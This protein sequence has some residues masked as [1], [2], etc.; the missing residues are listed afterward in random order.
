MGLDKLYDR[1][2]EMVM[3][4]NSFSNPIKKQKLSFWPEYVNDA[5]LAYGYNETRVYIKPS[6]EMI[7]RCDEALLWVLDMPL[8]DRKI[9]WLR[10]SKMSWRR[11]CAFFSCNKD[12]A[13]SKHTLALVRLQHKIRHL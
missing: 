2:E 12:T 4:C 13:K 10:G 5:N 8:E 9:V 3:V 11:I 7:D 6:N 1:L